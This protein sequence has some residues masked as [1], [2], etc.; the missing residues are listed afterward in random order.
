M[1][2]QFKKILPRV[3]LGLILAGAAAWLIYRFTAEKNLQLVSPNGKEIWQAGKTYQITWKAKNIGKVAIILTKGDSSTTVKWIAKD[4]PAG[5]K[6]YDWQIFV[7]ETPGQDYKVSIL[8][9][10]WK[11]GNKVDYSN[12]NFTIS[13]PQFA[14]CDDLS[15]GAEWLFLPSDYPNQRQVFITDTSFN[16]NL[17]GLGGADEKCQAAAQKAGLEGN[18]KAFL[19][20]DDTLAKDRLKLDG[21]FV[22]AKSSATLPEGKTCHRFLGKDFNEFFAK[23]S[24]S[25]TLNKDKLEETFLNHLSGVWLGR[26]NADSKKDCIA[27]SGQFPSLDISKNYSFTTT[28]QNWTSDR[29][30]V[31]GYPPESGENTQFP[32]C[33]TT[34]GKRID[35]VGLAGLSSGLVG[36]DS[37]TQVFSPAIG[38]TC[39]STQRLL[40]VQQ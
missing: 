12:D 40:C 38:I 33:Y 11:E 32:V 16:G 31:L 9:Y 39:N 37:K 26:I 2:F 18:W 19:G 22:E 3:I 21:I 27:I 35:T 23:L 25:L 30:L 6:K 15:I 34:E 17:A 14:S 13:G 4:I 7:W 24:D 8:E 28:C 10:P 20:S 29:K 1:T 36:S 5:R